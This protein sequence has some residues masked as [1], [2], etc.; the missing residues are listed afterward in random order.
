MRLLLILAAAAAFAADLT[1]DLLNAARSGHTA[2]VEALLAK[3]AN[4][5][6]AEKDG[7]TALML[8]ARH[9]RVETVRALLAKGAKVDVRDRDGWTAYALAL[10]EGHDA[11][12]KLLPEPAPFTVFLDLSAVPEN[13]YSSCFL[14]PAQLM[15]Q[16]AELKLDVVTGV[17]LHEYA[18]ENGKGR[19]QLA[20]LE[21]ADAILHL[22]VRPS[23]SCR[24]N[25]MMDNVSLAIDAH[26]ERTRDH[27][28]LFQ[29]TFGAGL[30]GLHARSVGSPSQYQAFLPEWARSHAGSIYWAVV[31]AWLRAP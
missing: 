20:A 29:K 31:E 10:E 9:G 8:A 14:T 5:E 1:P 25:Q 17:A 11:V 26:L 21:P 15:Q 3:G 18:T 13:L 16:V 12:L 27:S 19:M 6:G 7:R 23:V 24:Q 2:Q 28:I 30:K 4:I 22:A